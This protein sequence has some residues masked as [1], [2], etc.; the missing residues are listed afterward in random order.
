MR[1][2]FGPKLSLYH[3]SLVDQEKEEKWWWLEFKKKYFIHTINFDRISL[4]MCKKC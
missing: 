2:A 4:S 3:L 1:G